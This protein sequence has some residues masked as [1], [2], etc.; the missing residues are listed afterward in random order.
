M[1]TW[2]TKSKSGMNHDIQRPDCQLIHVLK[3]DMSRTEELTVKFRTLTYDLERMRSLH[4]KEVEKAA[5]AERE[6]N[7]YKSKLA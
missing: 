4:E 7:L 3:Q 5:N 2:A 6:M 1:S